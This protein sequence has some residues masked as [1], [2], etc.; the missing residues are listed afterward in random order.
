[1][2]FIYLLL[3]LICSAANEIIELMLKKRAIDLE[4][5]IR[6]LLCPGTES[7]TNDI[8]QKLYNHALINNLFG[9]TYED[10]RIGSGLRRLLRTQLPSYIPARNFALALMDLVGTVPAATPLEQG[11]P[12]APPPPPPAIEP[13]SGA[14]GATLAPPAAVTPA[15]VVVNI[16][17]TEEGGT[18]PAVPAASEIPPP[19]PGSVDNPVMRLRDAICS[20]PLLTEVSRRSLVTCL[21]AAGKDVVK[22]RENIENWYNSSMDRVSSWYKRR[23]QLTIMVIGFFVAITVNVDTITV[24]KRLSTDEALRESL[25]AAADAYAKANAPPSATPAPSPTDPAKTST[26]TTTATATVT[27][28]P[29]PTPTPLPECV[30]DEKSPECRNAKELQKAC[31]NPDSA[32]CQRETALQKACADPNSADCKTERMQKA[33]ED[34]DS[35]ACRREKNVQQACEDPTSDDCKTAMNLQKACAD[36]D[37]FECQRAEACTEPDSAECGRARALEKACSDPNSPKC[38]YLSSQQQLR[39]LGL[40]IGWDDKSDP[41][42]NFTGWTWAGDHGGWWDQL[43]WHWLGWL[44]TALAISLGAPFWFDLLNK[45]IVIR[46][47]VKPHEKSPEEESKD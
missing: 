25:V 11:K 3:S 27:P 39:A 12:A 18:L 15:Q 13:L 4:R 21:D 28:T 43:Q 5:G 17:S 47:A 29:I 20:S 10:S 41:K 45:F 14:A 22:A 36:P 37:S 33:C 32:E 1:M 44:L 23:A 16:P 38:K 46:S 24:A 19:A 42:R 34:P 9:G 26:T 30:K 35:D 2:I 31:K 7:G 8:V 40:P 6:E